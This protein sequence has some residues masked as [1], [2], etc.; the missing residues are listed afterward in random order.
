MNMI[1]NVVMA[2]CKEAEKQGH[3]IEDGKIWVE[4]GDL[5]V[6]SVDA[7]VLARVA[8]EAMEIPSA[9]MI[10]AGINCDDWA[11][12]EQDATKLIASTFSAMIKEAI[13]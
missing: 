3:I 4:P 9:E 6:S 12:G 1:D 11:D 2:I 13:K 10:N 8:I 7:V 5:M